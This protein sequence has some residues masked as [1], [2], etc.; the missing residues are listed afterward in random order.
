METSSPANLN[1]LL[2]QEKYGMKIYVS[3]EKQNTSQT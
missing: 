3:K 1:S 2:L